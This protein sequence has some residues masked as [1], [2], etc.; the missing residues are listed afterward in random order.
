MSYNIIFLSNDC[1]SFQKVL[2]DIILNKNHSILLEH[3]RRGTNVKVIL[4]KI[5]NHKSQI[6]LC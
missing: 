2:F 3:A 5:S 1:I 4:I 6:K